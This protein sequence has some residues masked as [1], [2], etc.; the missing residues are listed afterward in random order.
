[1]NYLNGLAPIV[2]V[3]GPGNLHHLTY[4]SVVGGTGAVG[5]VSTTNEG[6]TNFLLGFSYNYLGFEVRVL[7]GRQGPRVMA[8]LGQLDLPRACGVKLGK[9]N[10]R[11]VG[12]RG[13]PRLECR[14][15]GISRRECQ[16]WGSSVL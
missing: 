7:L 8:H 2:T 14:D 12:G 9:R 13:H 15:A 16:R 4:A 10:G 3:Y 11:A 5:M 1:M 6:T